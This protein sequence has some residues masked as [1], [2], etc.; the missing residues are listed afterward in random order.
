MVK[1]FYCK[2]TGSNKNKRSCIHW[3][4]NADQIE[5]QQDVEKMGFVLIV[6]KV[7]LRSHEGVTLNPYLFECQQW[8]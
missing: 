1:D 5:V 4:R 2:Q 3:S 6:W 7:F 8:L